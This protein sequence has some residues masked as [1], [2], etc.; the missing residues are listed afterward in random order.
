MTAYNPATFRAVPLFH[1]LFQQPFD[2]ILFDIFDV[3]Y[4]A[5]VV[6]SA[7][8]FIECFYPVAWK[9][10]TFITEPY[11][12]FS[13]LFALF[14]VVTVSSLY[15]A[16][17]AVCLPNSLLLQIVYHRQVIGTYAAVHTAWSNEFLFHYNQF[18]HDSIVIKILAFSFKYLIS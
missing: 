11:K 10:F 3:L 14:C 7:I 12:S 13:K 16:T 9:I 1:F 18:N 15:S 5:H 6:K 17:G 4:H 8:A 2:A